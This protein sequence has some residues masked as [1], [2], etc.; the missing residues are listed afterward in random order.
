LELL[1]GSAEWFNPAGVGS[2]FAEPVAWKTFV[3]EEGNS[4]TSLCLS[5]ST[6]I[7]PTWQFRMEKLEAEFAIAFVEGVTKGS[8]VGQATIGLL[9]ICTPFAC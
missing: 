2:H 8:V 7:W 6:G 4:I 1:C 9:L 5:A 3:E